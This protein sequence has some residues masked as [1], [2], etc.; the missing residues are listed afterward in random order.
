MNVAADFLSSALAAGVTDH[1]V[2]GSV[3]T[4]REFRGSR[5]DIVEAPPENTVSTKTNQKQD[6]AERPQIVRRIAL[7]GIARPEPVAK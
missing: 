2:A 3:R 1:P 4:I 5:S 7:V 6:K